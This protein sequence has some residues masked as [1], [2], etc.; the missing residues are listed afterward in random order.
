MCRLVVCGPSRQIEVAVPA[1]VVV[2]DLL[3]ALLH[4]LGEGLA[5]AGLAHGGWVLQRVGAVPVD[6]ESSVA[7]LGLNDGE[8]VHLRPRAEQLPEVDFDDLID[9]IA[10]GVRDRAGRWRPEMSRWVAWAVSGVLLALG[11]VALAGDGPVGA[12]ALVAVGVAVLALAGAF[13]VAR[14]AEERIF[15][16]VLAVAGVGYATA[17]GLIMPGGAEAVGPQVFA[18]SVGGA[19]AAVVAAGLLGVATPLFT[20]LATTLLLGAVGGAVATAAGL[21]GVGAAAVVAVVATVLVPMVAMVAFRLAGMRLAPL[22]TQ[23]EHL[24]EEISPEPAAPVMDKA[25]VTDRYMT[26][27]YAGLGAAT[28]V[29]LLVV[30][31]AGGWAELTLVALVA[32]VWLLSARPMTSA[33]H[34]L[35]Q[36]VP[37]LA[38]LATV[39]LAGLAVLPPLGRLGTLS[40]LPVAVTALLMASRSLPERRMMP[41]WGRVG[42]V[43]QTAA[44]LLTVPILLAVLGVYGYFRAIGG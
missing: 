2:A 43:A 26:A 24:Q 21:G 15:G 32:L 12:R 23:P 19:A 28:T 42:D 4:H 9:G 10:T 17:T 25:A 8:V 40:V 34:R 3:P 39:A 35:A 11:L 37:A 29:A 13:A 6:E 31:R 27:L 30:G 7:T 18:G 20:G 1:H 41:Y 44:T 38:G 5:D 22:P 16:V 33:W 36:A 14:A